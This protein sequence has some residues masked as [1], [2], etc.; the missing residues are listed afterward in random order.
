MKKRLLTLSMVSLLTLGLASCSD[1]DAKK[2]S[3]GKDI[4]VS[5]ETEGGVVNYT[6]DDL[7]DNY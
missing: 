2:T 1:V 5:I 6:A 4:I 3:D 7:L